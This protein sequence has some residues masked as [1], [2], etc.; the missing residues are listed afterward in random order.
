[1]KLKILHLLSVKRDDLEFFK[2]LYA[3]LPISYTFKP[4]QDG[5][6]TPQAS[7]HFWSNS[8]KTEVMVTSLMEMLEH[9][10][11]SQR[12]KNENKFI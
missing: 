9:G 6:V 5:G 10:N 12:N 3:F 1:M 4:T 2:N 7:G 11:N 8:Y